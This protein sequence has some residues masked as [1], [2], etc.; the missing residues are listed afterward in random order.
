MVFSYLM[1]IGKAQ[2]VLE[3]YQFLLN[4]IISKYLPRFIKV[5]YQI[6]SFIF[7]EFHMRKHIISVSRN[8]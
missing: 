4:V 3:K 8:L 6:I 7:D 2:A 1:T 5:S